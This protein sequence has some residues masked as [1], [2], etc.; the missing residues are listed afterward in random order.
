MIEKEVFSL[1]IL[2][3]FLVVGNGSG[4]GGNATTPPT[5]N[6]RQQYTL[7]EL[8]FVC[9]FCPARY[10]TKPGLQ[11]HLTKHKETNTDYRPST[12]SAAENGGASSS[13]SSSSAAAG[14]MKPKYMNSPM[15]HPHPPQHPMYAG[16]PPPGGPMIHSNPGNRHVN[17]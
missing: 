12:S 14:M 5:G 9:E 13:P 8:P 2:C 3:F 17:G 16:H 1:I 15:D 10:K 6:R 4:N 7:A 11:Y